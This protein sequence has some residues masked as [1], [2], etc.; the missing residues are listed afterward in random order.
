MSRSKGRSSL[1][2]ARYAAQLIYLMICICL[3]Y[4]PRGGLRPCDGIYHHCICAFDVWGVPASPP[5]PCDRLYHCEKRHY[6][7]IIITSI[8]KAPYLRD[9]PVHRRVHTLQ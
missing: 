5:K 2:E 1:H 4:V 3:P 9:Q 8:Y 7:F 6:Y